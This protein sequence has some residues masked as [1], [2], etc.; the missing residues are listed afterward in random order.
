[1][2]NKMPAQTYAVD[3]GQSNDFVDAMRYHYT[4]SYILGPTIQFKSF[5][6]EKPMKLP[7]LKTAAANYKKAQKAVR[8]TWDARLTAVGVAQKALTARDAAEAAHTNAKNKEVE[9]KLILLQ[10]AGK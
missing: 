6:K 1:M 10:V 5:T 3:V 7:S 2:S 4:T 8:K 9:A